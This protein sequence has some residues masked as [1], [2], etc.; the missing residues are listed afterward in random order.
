MK[1]SRGVYN[2]LNKQNI[3]LSVIVIVQVGKLAELRTARG[4]VHV[5]DGSLEAGALWCWFKSLDKVFAMIL[6]HKDQRDFVLKW[7]L[8]QSIK[9]SLHQDKEER[10]MCL[11]A[12]SITI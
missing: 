5:R 10:E 1:N 3:V 4:H 12:H 6:V 2:T 8:E 9:L 7:P 11:V